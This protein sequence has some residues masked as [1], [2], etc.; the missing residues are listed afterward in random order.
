[1]ADGAGYVGPLLG[2]IS[3]GITGLG[4]GFVGEILRAKVLAVRSELR[5]LDDLRDLV[6][7]AV[8]TLNR[9]AAPDQG[10]LSKLSVERS[11]LGVNLTRMKF[12]PIEWARVV[13]GL[14]E[15]SYLVMLLEDASSTKPR[16][17]THDTE[18]PFEDLRRAI[19]SAAERRYVMF[20]IMGP[21]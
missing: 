2:A 8:M 20:R 11:R 21:G 9:G 3:G 19:M 14:K 10:A 13:G 4:A 17:F 5:R 18:A 1:M 7:A 15:V 12:H 6:N 16:T